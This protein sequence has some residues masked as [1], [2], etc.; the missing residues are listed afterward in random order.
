M[1]ANKSERRK[2]QMSENSL[3]S[4]GWVYTYEEYLISALSD[5]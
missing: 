3:S 1:P 5:I 4:Q 2:E